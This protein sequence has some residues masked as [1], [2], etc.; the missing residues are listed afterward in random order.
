M[1]MEELP[2]IGES[3]ETLSSYELIS[4]YINRGW[5]GKPGLKEGLEAEFAA[6][7]LPLPEPFPPAPPPPPPGPKPMSRDTFVSWLLLIYTVSGL[8]Y[9]WLYLPMRL[10]R[11]DFDKDKKQRLAQAGVALAYQVLEVVTYIALSPDI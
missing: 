1:R 3:L 10:I 2:E 4:L 11:G 9:A 6:R 7:R 5:E 8:V